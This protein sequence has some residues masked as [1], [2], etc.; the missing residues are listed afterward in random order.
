MKINAV[1]A[2]RNIGI[3]DKGLVMSLNV[4]SKCMVTVANIIQIPL[5]DDHARTVIRG[6]PILYGKEGQF[7]LTINR[8]KHVYGIQ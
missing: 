3:G 6:Y 2:T 7:L 1:Q 4:C 5:M 8:D